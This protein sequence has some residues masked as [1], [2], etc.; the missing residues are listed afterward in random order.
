[1]EIRMVSK[2]GVKMKEVT[3]LIGHVLD[4]N[5]GLMTCELVETEQGVCPMVTIGH[6]DVHVGRLGS[7]VSVQQ[8]DLRVVA[9]VTRMRQRE[10]LPETG[11]AEDSDAM[12]A[13]SER[14]LDLTP[15]GSVNETG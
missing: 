8:G 12:E 6:E 1:M 9:M 14:T 4:V 2:G 7:Y 13:I 5:E 11:G 3:T 15:V 10:R